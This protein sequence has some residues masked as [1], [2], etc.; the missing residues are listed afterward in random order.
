MYSLKELEQ[1]VWFQGWVL[2][3]SV[4]T[5][6]IFIRRGA[7]Y[8]FWT[9][10]RNR[11]D[12]INKVLKTD[13]HA[14]PKLTCGFR[15]LFRLQPG[16]ILG[17]AVNTRYYEVL[18]FSIEAEPR[19]LEGRN[20][21]LFL[22]N[23]TNKSI[24]QY[25]G[26]LLLSTQQIAAWKS[27]LAELTM[28]QKTAFNGK[29]AL[30]VAPSK[31]LVFPQY[32]PYAKGEF[33]VMEQ[34]LALSQ[35]YTNIIFPIEQ[36]Q[37]MPER[38]FRVTDTH[39]TYAGAREATVVLAELLLDTATDIRNIFA[40]D[41]Y[42]QHKVMGDLGNKLYPPRYADEQVLRNASHKPFLLYDNMLSNFGRVKVIKNDN[43][44]NT[45]HCVI[46]GSSSVYTML[47]FLC[48]VF[49]TITFF[50]TAGNIDKSL[51]S[52]LAPDIV[53]AQTNCRFLIRPPSVEYDL[54]RVIT[55]K[56][57][58]LGE[59]AATELFLSCKKQARG[60]EHKTVALLQD[61]LEKAFYHSGFKIE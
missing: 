41:V 37:S 15:Q 57:L 9:L 7:D 47:D 26:A 31:E 23:D 12:V 5:V 32:Y 20:G 3:Q 8:F 40:K 53:I 22:D 25:C 17:F 54:R 28:L 38:S 19:P 50:H 34:F 14:H 13:A 49:G 4:L 35:K 44:L 48:R 27:Y 1:G 61:L 45:L 10:D 43:A 21:W 60:T 59:P 55:E 58:Q 51:I 46:F 52:Q 56:L 2:S 29:S 18:Q 30:L 16:D 39:W 42:A 36:L 6:E 33:T 11:P 24:E